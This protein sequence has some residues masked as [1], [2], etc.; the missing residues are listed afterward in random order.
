E[1]AVGS[2]EQGGASARAGIGSYAV[3]RGQKQAASL[4]LD[5][6][7]RAHI[8]IEVRD[9]PWSRRIYTAYDVKVDGPASGNTGN[10]NDPDGAPE[11]QVRIFLCGS[12][13]RDSHRHQ[14]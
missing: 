2:T 10:R 7:F 14:P 13:A 9:A 8:G 6:P 1:R 3:A 11:L 4:G 12:H 5:P